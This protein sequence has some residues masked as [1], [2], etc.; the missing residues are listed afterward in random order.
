MMIE[1]FHTGTANFPQ[2]PDFRSSHDLIKDS[3]GGDVDLSTMP[4]DLVKLCREMWAQVSDLPCSVIHGDLNQDNLL[5][6]YQGKIVMLDWDECRRDVCAFDLG[7]I[8][9]QTGR[10]RRALIAWEVACAWQIEPDYAREMAQHLRDVSI[11]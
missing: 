10:T 4:S 5:Q 11:K 3:Q 2:R 6:T 9:G 7:P 1:D 8:T